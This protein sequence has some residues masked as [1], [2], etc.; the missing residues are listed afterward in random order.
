[1]TRS[2]TTPLTPP[3]TFAVLLG[4]VAT[5]FVALL[6]G[7]T[8]AASAA[9]DP[10]AVTV[11]AP[12]PT[13][14]YGQAVSLTPTY[15]TTTDATPVTPVTPATCHAAFYSTST[16]TVTY[17]DPGTY[18][19]TCSGAADPRYT[20]TYVSGTLTITAPPPCRPFADVGPDNHFC[21]DIQWL[22]A[23]HITTGYPDGGYHPTAPVTREQMAVFLY[24]Y[25][26][27]GVPAPA[28][29]SKPFP[30]VSA[31]S[32]FC[33][34]IKWLAAQHISQGYAADGTFRPGLPV[35]RQE[36]AAFLYRLTLTGTAAPE[37]TFSPF[38]DVFA[39]DEFCSVIK[40][41]VEHDV[42]GGYPDGNFHPTWVV[43]RQEMAAFLHRL[44]VVTHP[45]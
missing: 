44:Y 37:C 39:Q 23:H 24:R 31:T 27:P 7:T 10:V 14:A 26:N 21:P 32:S 42:A 30:D 33:P 41:S 20:F 9:T 8:A 28:C 38:N 13:V 29:T 4:A 12:S 15:A 40:W 22:A 45:S 6:F 17:P 35:G 18:A 16:P 11:T 36:M 19:V 34:E 5:L 2:A 25:A 1:M 43:G 3:R